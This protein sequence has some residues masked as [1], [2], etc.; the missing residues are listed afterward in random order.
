M[1]EK[2]FTFLIKCDRINDVD[3][4]GC[5]GIG[6]RD[7]LRIYFERVGVQVPSSAPKEYNPNH[8]LVTSEWFGLTFYLET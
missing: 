6:R 5:G 7:R 3:S 2:R 1:R 4:S 8:V